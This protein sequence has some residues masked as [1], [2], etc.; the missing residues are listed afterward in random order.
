MSKIN[1]TFN[2]IR[3]D[4]SAPITRSEYNALVSKL[5][6]MKRDIERMSSVNSISSAVS[7]VLGSAPGGGSSVSGVEIH[8]VSKA[9]TAGTPSAEVFLAPALLLTLPVSYV[10]VDGMMST[11]FPKV[12]SLTVTG[13][14]MTPIQDGTAIYSYILL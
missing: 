1:Q 12:E 4:A 8:V 14:T 13:F 10:T 3:G 6:S 9:V 7:Q 2:P 5:N 11:E